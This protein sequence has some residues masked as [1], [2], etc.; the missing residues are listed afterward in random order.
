MNDLITQ[1]HWPE[2]HQRY[3]QAL[4]RAVAYILG[5][6]NVSGIIASGT[7]LRGNPGPSSDLDIYVI[8]AEDYRQR[9]QKFFNNVPAEIFVNPPQAIEGYFQE[10]QADRRPLTAHMLATGHVIL[11]RAPIVEALRAKARTLL[12]QPPAAPENLVMPRYL[13]AL[14][15]EDALDVTETDPATAQ[16]ILSQAVTEMLKFPFIER[17]KFFP[18]TKDLLSELDKIDAETAGLARRFFEVEEFNVRLEIACQ[19]A[20]RTIQARGFFEWE[21]DPE[22]IPPSDSVSVI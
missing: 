10:E 4:R 19:I 2:L 20:D 12:S 9:V 21:K 14:I 6:Y 22:E 3:D 16:M 1:C 7:I 18:R 15:L 8:H 5:R 11:N 17:G 13:T